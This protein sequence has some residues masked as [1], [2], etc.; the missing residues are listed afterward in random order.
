M[1]RAMIIA[2]WVV[3]AAGPVRADLVAPLDPITVANN[4]TLGPGGHGTMGILDA[5]GNIIPS[6]VVLYPNASDV[7]T[8][9]FG[10][11]WPYVTPVL[12]AGNL[13]GLVWDTDEV[14]LLGAGPAGPFVTNNIGTTPAAG[15]AFINSIVSPLSGTEGVL[16]IQQ[17]PVSPFI[18]RSSSTIPFFRATFRAQA[19]FPNDGLLDLFAPSAATSQMPQTFFGVGVLFTFFTTT[20]TTGPSGTVNTH[21]NPTP[22]GPF[23]NTGSSRPTFGLELIPEPASVSLLAV[24]LFAIAAGAR[25]RQRRSSHDR[26]GWPRSYSTWEH[27]FSSE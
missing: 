11:H 1:K 25:Q 19:P 17:S 10:I 6:N 18:L 12:V 21:I 7:I 15:A 8:V 22:V 4:L 14:V 13:N 16:G 5:G 23:I 20:M 27:D 24:G 26:S 2:G 9:T 3:L